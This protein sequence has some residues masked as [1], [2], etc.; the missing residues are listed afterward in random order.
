VTTTTHDLATTNQNQIKQALPGGSKGGSKK[1]G[2]TGTERRPRQQQQQQPPP[3]QQPQQHHHNVEL[4]ASSQRHVRWDA[5]PLC[6]QAVAS[7]RFSEHL[8]VKVS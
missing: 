4:T 3:Q 1:G 7:K 8:V 2:G 6:F 5:F